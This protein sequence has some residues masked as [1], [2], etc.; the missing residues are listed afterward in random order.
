MM[1]AVGFIC[2]VWAYGLLGIVTLFTLH[3]YLPQYPPGT[4]LFVI[5]FWPVVAWRA[6]RFRRALK[7]FRPLQRDFLK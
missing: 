4:G 5:A 6:W 1:I 2:A 7:D 3:D